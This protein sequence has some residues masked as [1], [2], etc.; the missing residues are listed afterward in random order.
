MFEWFAGLNPQV[1]SG[2]IAGLTAALST[3]L[4]VWLTQRYASKNHQLTLEDNQRTREEN[5][6]QLKLNLDAS[7]QK[8]RDELA[9]KR[10]DRTFDVKLKS[11]SELLE[12]LT[13]LSVLA[14]SQSSTDEELTGV[15]NEI[16]GLA[17]RVSFLYNSTS[18]TA[19]VKNADE[20]YE[21]FN[22]LKES[23]EEYKNAQDWFS[24]T[25]ETPGDPWLYDYESAMKDKG[26]TPGEELERTKKAYDWH[27]GNLDSKNVSLSVITGFLRRELRENLDGENEK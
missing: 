10:T 1:Q 18:A 22:N 21:S 15:L 2:W 7:N 19:I 14:Q 27:V 6:L 25:E 9:E 3:G 8:H 4:T 5:R 24:I 23:S 20:L 16:K 12:A 11:G 26:T 13:K 17:T